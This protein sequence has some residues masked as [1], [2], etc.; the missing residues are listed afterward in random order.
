MSIHTVRTA[1]LRHW[2][3]ICV[4]S[5]PQVRDPRADS[6][7]W[8]PPSRLSRVD[9]DMPSV[10]GLGDPVFALSPTA[11]CSTPTAWP[12]RCSAGSPPT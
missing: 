8:Q 2:T 5:V 10:D 3:F 1:A 7:P 4:S 9:P 12:A 6:T 11:S